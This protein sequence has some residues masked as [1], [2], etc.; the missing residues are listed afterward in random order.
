MPGAPT[1]ANEP[2]LSCV[3]K[4]SY[5]IEALPFYAD[6]ILTSASTSDDYCYLITPYSI[7]MVRL[8]SNRV[9]EVFV[10][11]LG[12]TIREKFKEDR[13][14]MFFPQQT[15]TERSSI[16]VYASQE[17]K[18]DGTSR[19][20]SLP[21]HRLL[22][23]SEG[24]TYTIITIRFDQAEIDIAEAFFQQVTAADKMTASSICTVPAAAPQ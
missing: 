18:L 17:L 6:K 16:E 14:K 23:L 3:L 8:E 15:S 21:N 9:T 13:Q 12:L 19:L 2:Q 22:L 20:L 11:T 7:C 4:F 1:N 24:G 10:S 5:T